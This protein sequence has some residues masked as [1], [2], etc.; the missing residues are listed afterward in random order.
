MVAK[1]IEQVGKKK[2]KEENQSRDFLSLSLSSL[3]RGV[4]G[5]EKEKKKGKKYQFGKPRG[6]SPF[7]L[8]SLV[9]GITPRAIPSRGRQC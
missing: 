7:S 8:G 6:S 2:I 1:S 5:D 4:E 9:L 3:S